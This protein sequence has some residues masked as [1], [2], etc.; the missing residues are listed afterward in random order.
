M[1]EIGHCPECMT[2]WDVGKEGKDCPDCLEQPFPKKE[3][4]EKEPVKKSGKTKTK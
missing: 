3:I 2:E 4:K 1:S